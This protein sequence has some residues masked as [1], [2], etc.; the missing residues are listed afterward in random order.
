MLKDAISKINYKFL[1]ILVA[2]IIIRIIYFIGLYYIVFP[3]AQDYYNA[4]Q[5]YFE[6]DYTSFREPVLPFFTFIILIFTKNPVFSVKL[7]SF[8]AGILTICAS[9]IVFKRASLNIFKE[10]INKEQKSEF[11]GLLVSL[12]YSLDDE[13]VFNSVMG[14]REELISLILILI[15][16]FVFIKE[17]NNSFKDKIVIVTLFVILSFLHITG[18]IFTSLSVVIGFII[19][20]FKLLNLNFNISSKNIIII[21]LTSTICLSIWFLHCAIVNNDPFYTMSVNQKWF[22]EKKHVKYDSIPHLIKFILKGFRYGI[23]NEFLLLSGNISLFFVALVCL[24]IINFYKKKIIFFIGIILIFNFVYLCPFIAV[25]KCSR[26]ILYFKPL[27]Y[28][29]GWLIFIDI[30]FKNTK[31]KKLTIN[32]LERKFSLPFF[33]LFLSMIAL[34][35]LSYLFECIN[36]FIELRTQEEVIIILDDL[37]NNFILIFN[38]ILLGILILPYLYENKDYKNI[39]ADSTNSKSINTE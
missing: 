17:D 39:F 26:L 3:D 22:R 9:Y 33:F 18:A 32:I 38:I 35:I 1:I 24:S 12:C 14:L 21:I 25:Y 7:V 15:L 28:F 34:L 5:M 13:A 10:D 4:A 19:I 36:Y 6:L 31:N 20:K 27:I 16:Y 23:F 2:G 37:K 8:I 30:W 29:L 11:I